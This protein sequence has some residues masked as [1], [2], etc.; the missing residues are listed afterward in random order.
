MHIHSLL[1]NYITHTTSRLHAI[2]MR[3]ANGYELTHSGADG[4]SLSGAAR[5]HGTASMEIIFV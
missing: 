4:L 1:L 2:R 5:V 3:N